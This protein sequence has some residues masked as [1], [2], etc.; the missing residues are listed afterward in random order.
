M[1]CYLAMDSESC[2]DCPRALGNVRCTS[3]VASIRRVGRSDRDACDRDVLCRHAQ[4]RRIASQPVARGIGAGGVGSRG[5]TVH[6]WAAEQLAAADRASSR[7]TV[8]PK[9][10]S[11]GP[12]AELEAVRRAP[13]ARKTKGV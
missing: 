8:N 11:A 3:F 4:A 10:N 7:E 12:A 2:H 13:A 1:V 6:P 5:P 9:A